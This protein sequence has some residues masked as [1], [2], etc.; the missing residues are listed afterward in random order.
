M[1]ITH[2]TADIK[3]KRLF[4]FGNDQRTSI[5][6]DVY[7]MCCMWDGPK[8]VTTPG[9]DFAAL[10]SLMFEAVSGASDE[11]LAGAI[12]RYAR[13]AERKQWDKEGEDDDPDDNFHTEKNEMYASSHAIEL[14]KQVLQKPGLTDKAIGLLSLRLQHEQRK[15]E[16]ART[17][18][19]PRQ[20]YVGQ[21]NREQ[22][23]G[24]LIEAV[25]RL[26]PEQIADLD[27]M[28]MKGKSLSACDIERG[29]RIRADRKRVD[30]N[31]EPERN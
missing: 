24:M 7:H 19:G 30:A 17:R 20:V 11:G 25:N 6:E 10:C 26:K 9:S 13:S 2:T 16:E 27:E 31:S 5:V 4:I 3:P 28:I 8:L 22:W 29:Q 1:E 14:C 18:Y 15:H 23:D 12:N 21:M